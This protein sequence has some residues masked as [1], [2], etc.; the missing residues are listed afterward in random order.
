MEERK[1]GKKRRRKKGCIPVTEGHR[2]EVLSSSVRREGF[3]ESVPAIFR[4]FGAIPPI[5]YGF[6]II[7]FFEINISACQ[8]L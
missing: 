7:R 5:T 8:H 1:V 6:G 2:R 3:W 4:D